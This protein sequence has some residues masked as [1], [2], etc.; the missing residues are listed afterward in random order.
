MRPN[1]SADLE[2]IATN[3]GAPVNAVGA[4]NGANR[5]TKRAARFLVKMPL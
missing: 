4:L 3:T 2:A 1:G 5:R